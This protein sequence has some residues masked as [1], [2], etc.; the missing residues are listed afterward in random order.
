MG[1][2]YVNHAQHLN[3]HKANGF[4]GLLYCYF[5]SNQIIFI[6]LRSSKDYYKRSRDGV[7]IWKGSSVYELLRGSMCA[8][9]MGCGRR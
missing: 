4:Y 2:F 7:G 5:C 3:M 6:G 1:Y 9:G 8:K